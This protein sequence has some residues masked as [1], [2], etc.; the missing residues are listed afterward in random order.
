MTVIAVA[1]KGGT[2]KTLVSALLVHFISSKNDRV[3]AVDADPD[4]NLPDALGV[5]D[6]VT[7]TLG[8]IRELFQV[9]RDDMGTM[10]KEQWLEGKIYGE[11][12]CECPK[13]DLLVMGRPEGEGCYC[14]ANS[15][16]RGV[17]RRLLRHYDYIIID[18]EAGLEH[19]SRKTIDSADYIVIVTDMS[20]KGLATA[21]RIKDLLSELKIGVKDV[22]LIAN[23]ISSKEVEERVKAFADEEGMK[24]LAV[25]PYEEKVAELDLEG[26]PI[27]KLG[28]DSEVYRK[29][30][31]VANFFLKIKVTA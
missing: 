23:R 12:I 7:K 11:A 16:L 30:Q 9:S 21:K 22:F 28:E 4:S 15:L 25:L 5:A 8:D 14:F 1:G 27:T 3:L 24:L 6:E 20:K 19:F 18:S 13:Y 26:E 31:E 29:M 2:G 10:N 17:L